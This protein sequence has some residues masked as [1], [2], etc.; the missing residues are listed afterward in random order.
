MTTLLAFDPSMRATGWFVLDLE[1]MRARAGGAIE[2]LALASRDDWG[3]ERLADDARCG[4]E[5]C[6]AVTRLCGLYEPNVIALEAPLGAQDARA[7]AVLARS[8]QAVVDGIWCGARSMKPFYVSSHA[9]KWAATGA[10]RPKNGKADVQQGVIDRFGRTRMSELAASAKS[11][12]GREGV[13]DAAAVALL[14]A[15]LPE[16]RAL[17]AQER[18]SE[19]RLVP[20]IQRIN[21]RLFGDEYTS[22]GARV[23]GDGT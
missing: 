14:A 12:A 16:V 8:N 4:R 23:K 20:G 7:A 15:R 18:V 2:P 1:T 21:E 3:L 10:K 13:Y 11:P 19:P 6:A 9:A 5:L 17:L 22:D